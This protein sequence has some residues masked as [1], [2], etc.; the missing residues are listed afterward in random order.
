MQNSE[1]FLRFFKPSS[2]KL[3]NEQIII[4][5]IEKNKNILSRITKSLSK[6]FRKFCKIIYIYLGVYLCVICYIK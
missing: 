2:R 6:F 3:L 5:N 1:L 4:K